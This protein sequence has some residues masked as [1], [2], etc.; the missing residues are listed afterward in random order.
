MQNE[1]WREVKGVIGYFISSLGRVRSLKM[2]K[3]IIMSQCDH[4]R[5]YKVVWLYIAPGSRK[6]FFIH[7]LVAE[8]FIPN[9]ENKD[10]VNHR[11]SNKTNN[12]LSNLE[13][14]TYGE[15]T[16]YYYENRTSVTMDEYPF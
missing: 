6:K 10:V 13:W 11:D 7:R 1:E 9:P 4:Y 8:A 3:E 12:T 15:N 16:R 2:K 5:G 14:M